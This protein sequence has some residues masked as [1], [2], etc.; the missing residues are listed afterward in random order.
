MA[1]RSARAGS[2]AQTMRRLSANAS[3]CCRRIAIE[4]GVELAGVART[5]P[6]ER[7][8]REPNQMPRVR[9]WLAAAHDR[10]QAYDG[11]RHRK[12]PV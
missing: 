5:N 12:S 9:V 2:R 8:P 10:R 3:G 6:F 1:R 4:G 11:I 7:R